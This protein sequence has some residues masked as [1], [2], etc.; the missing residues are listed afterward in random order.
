MTKCAEFKVHCITYVHLS[1]LSLQDNESQTF[2]TYEPSHNLSTVTAALSQ[3]SPAMY[4]H[5]H[6]IGRQSNWDGQPMYM[7]EQKL[8]KWAVW[9]QGKS[10]YNMH[11]LYSVRQRERQHRNRKGKYEAESSH[12]YTNW[13]RGGE[14]TKCTEFKV[15]SIMYVHL[16]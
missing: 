6:D 2:S 4:V 12:S 7:Y 15:H 11:P 9:G 1:K 5:T 3:D 13:V 14:I 16:S 10:D 8:R